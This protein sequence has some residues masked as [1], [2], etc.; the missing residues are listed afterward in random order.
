MNQRA[1]FGCRIII[2]EDDYFQAEDCRQMLEQA[3]AIVVAVSSKVPELSELTAQG[4]ID[5]ALI[6]I[7]LGPGLSLD[8][9]RGL[10]DQAIPFVF[11][12]GYD[13][14]M[15]PDDL[16]ASPCISKPADCVRVLGALEKL[17]VR[18]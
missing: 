18:R 12:T 2:V 15:L 16:S 6:D 1:L 3:G 14:E 5:A 10:R 17:V 11:L 13:A 7:N 8:F 4:S 9:A